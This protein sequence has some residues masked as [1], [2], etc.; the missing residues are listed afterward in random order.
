MKRRWRLSLGC[1]SIFLVIFAYRVLSVYEFRTGSCSAG[2]QPVIVA[3]T[4]P[5]RLL[6]MSY[7]IQGHASL[8]RSNHIEKVAEA[9]AEVK[10][11]II[12]INELHRKTWQS[13]FRDHV[14]EL[15]RLTGLNATFAPSYDQL[16]GEFGNG[17]LTRGK[18]LRTR[19]ARLPGAGEPRTMLAADVE[20]DGGIVTVYVTHLTAWEKLNRA[21]RALQL[22]CLAAHV[23]ESRHP[24]ILAGDLNAP[25]ES[26]EIVAF[27]QDSTLQMAGNGAGATHRVM[28]LWI[29]Y[30]FAD[31]GWKVISALPLD[32]GPSDHRPMV[33]ELRYGTP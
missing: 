29:D 22:Q 32:I 17:I 16:G 33:A 14:V 3:K 13:R 21:T 23:R 20:I 4:Y 18:I 30:V 7:N 5:K 1:L 12:C 10:P 6:V 9:I 8:L 2:R 19:I 15:Q 26:P 28:N 31:R 27:R 24:Y 11:D 25:P